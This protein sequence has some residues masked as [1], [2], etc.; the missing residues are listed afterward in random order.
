MATFS[1]CSLMREPQDII[2]RF[3]EHYQQIGASQ[4]FIYLDQESPKS[5]CKP[6]D[7]K[8][9]PQVSF[10]DCPPE[11]WNDHPRVSGVTE[12][13]NK[14]TQVFHDAIH[15][16]SS[17]WILFCDADEFLLGPELPSDMLSRVPDNLK[18]IRIRNTEAVWATG[19]HPYTP[20]SCGYERLPF[21][22]TRFGTFFLPLAIYGRFWREMSRGTTGHIQGKHMLRK[23]IIPGE[24]T[25][26]TSIIDGTH[27]PF[28][29]HICP[30]AKD[31]RIIHYDALGY[32]RWVR[33]W[34]MRT[35]GQ[36]VSNRMSPTRLRQ[37]KK[38]TSAFNV[39]EELKIFERYNTLD[40]WQRTLLR[41][42]GLIKPLQ[43][44]TP[45]PSK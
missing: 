7:F 33:K 5:T 6:L 17:E 8:Q 4:I 40:L 11:F 38:I 23:G 44:L 31:F 32:D 19:D 2:R 14:L 15:R 26:H 24:M 39:G 1:V 10:I 9:W 27:L 41:A 42:T 21:P 3:V 28:I 35:Q 34:R 43:Q 16:N 18:G 13:D 45:R 30:D 29:T 22:K 12:L 25:S 37:F 36:T 20:F